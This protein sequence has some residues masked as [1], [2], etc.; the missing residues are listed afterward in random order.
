MDLADWE[1]PD[2]GEVVHPSSLTEWKDALS[3][4]LGSRNDVPLL[5]CLDVAL[6]CGAST[7]VIETRYLD[8]DYRSEYS[9]YFSRTF[10]PIPDSTH[11]LHFFSEIIEPDQVADLPES[12]G[13]LGY[14]IVRPAPNGPVS[15]AMLTPP[16]SIEEAITTVVSETVHLFGQPLT[17]R[18]VP[19][20]QQ[21]TQ[22]GACAHVAAWVCHYTAFLRGDVGRR[23][24][25]DFS[26]QANASL[27]P[28]RSLPTQGLTVNQ[29]SDLFRTFDLPAIF[30]AL[31]ELP[32]QPLPWQPPA[33]Q[34]PAH[35]PGSPP[36]HPGTWDVRV[37]PLL[38]RYLN[39]G[40][41]VLVG[42]QDHAFVVCG[43]RRNPTNLNWIDFYRNDDQRGP[44]LPMANVL[45][46]VDPL[47]GHAHS[48]WQTV[49]VPAPDKIWLSPEAAERVGG[50]LMQNASAAA[51]TAVA[52]ITGSAVDSI[53]DLIAAESFSLRT[54]VAS[55]NRFKASLSARGLPPELVRRYRLARMPRFVLVVE[56]VERGLRSA[57]A[58][59]TIGQCIFD[60]TS[61]DHDP[62]L[63]AMDV[64]GVSWVFG[65][66]R[67]PGGVNFALA[68][69][70]VTG[71]VA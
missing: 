2:P 4:Y 37:V 21:D 38:C 3:R 64:H 33:P 47:T 1:S 58:A 62:G 39:S 48:L 19:F 10:A 46:D 25:A 11:R 68:T 49:H 45:A 27:H 34:P 41:P 16:P 32:E 59:C 65:P 30:Y 71:A 29:L 57:G 5:R 17:V 56:A 44:Y 28:A 43:Y 9:A 20:A 13:Y 31:G 66:D 60:A 50:L 42:T 55:S 67:T 12:P 14:V 7:L 15:R 61:D 23:P 22:L 54:Y 26:L 36:P 70:Y 6:E 35:A 63:L 24:R 52:T 40:M 69:P 8:L 51:S 18:A 53:D